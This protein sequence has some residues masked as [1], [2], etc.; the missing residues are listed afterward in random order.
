M[1]IEFNLVYRWHSL[2]PDTVRIDGHDYPATCALFN[3]DVVTNRGL[4]GLFEDATLQPA[5]EIG[6]FNT[7][8][9]L[10]DVE[11]AS[12][13]LGRLAGLA[14]AGPSRIVGTLVDYGLCHHQSPS[15]H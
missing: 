9:F 1:S 8:D 3:N 5:G 11:K 12:I 10:L 15:D 6:L 2:V 13:Q 7:P 14:S 4:G